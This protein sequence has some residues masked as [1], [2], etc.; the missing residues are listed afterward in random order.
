MTS[1]QATETYAKA[2]LGDAFDAD[3]FAQRVA[4]AKAR[5]AAQPEATLGEIDSAGAVNLAPSEYTEI[6][7]E[8]ELRPLPE[9]ERAQSRSEAI[10]TAIALSKRRRFGARKPPPKAF[11]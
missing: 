3:E 2:V 11:F 1:E 4:E 7:P 9:N 5:R 6:E 8:P 10:A